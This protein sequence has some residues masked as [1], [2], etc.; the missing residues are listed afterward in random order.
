MT[1]KPKVEAY[2]RRN[3]ENYISQVEPLY[4]M[5]TNMAL[6]LFC[7]PDYVGD[8]LAPVQYTP[9]HFGFFKRSFDQIL[10][11]GGSQ[12]FGPFTLAHTLFMVDEK[13]WN[14]SYAHTQG[15]VQ[16]FAQTAANTVQSRFKLDRDLEYPLTT[17]GIVTDGKR[18]TFVCFQLNTLNLQ[19]GSEDNG[20][21]NVFWAGPSLDLY[22]DVVVGKKLVGFNRDCARLIFKFLLHQPVR[23]RPRLMGGRSKAMPRYKMAS[24]G[25]QLS[26]LTLD[27]NGKVVVGKFHTDQ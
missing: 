10:P 24:D 8:G 25:M 3:G 23:R 4:I 7:Q 6:G 5:H 11:F 27:E 19:K 1:L 9:L 26:P 12:S 13:R 15:L 14:T 21:Y 22:R 18:F 20:K 17:Q 2:W 16:L